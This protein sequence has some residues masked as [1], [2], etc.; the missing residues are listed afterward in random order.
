MDHVQKVALT[1][2]EAAVFLNL[3]KNY[4]YK[5]ISL[6][7]IPYYKPMAGRV[8]FKP[9]ELESFLFRNRQSADYEATSV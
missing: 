4:I 1:I 2:D 9:S 6:K 3:S 8:F 7:K 5:L